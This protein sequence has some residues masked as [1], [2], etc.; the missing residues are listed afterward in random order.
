MGMLAIVLALEGGWAMSLG[1]SE[2]ALLALVAS[3]LTLTWGLYAIL[4]VELGPVD[5]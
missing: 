1:K 3:V 4:V 5:Q 2:V